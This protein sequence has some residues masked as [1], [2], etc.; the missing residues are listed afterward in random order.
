MLR[1]RRRERRTKLASLVVLVLVVA[2][3]AAIGVDRA[4][5]FVRHL[6]PQHHHHIASRVTPSTTVATTT[7]PGPPRCTSE[8]LQAYLFNWQITAGVLYEDVA[9]AD[10]SSAPC[11]LAGF[12]GLSVIAPGGGTLPSPVS[13]AA[14]L[15]ASA[16]ASTTPVA[17]SPGGRAWFELSY[18]VNCSMV[19]APGQASSTAP[20]DCYQGATLGVVVP[21]ATNTLD[22]DQ[23][24]SFTYG[25]AGFTVGPFGSQAPPSAPPTS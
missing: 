12:V 1:R 2:G 22:V 19:L 20:G 7:I 24:L 9:L 3:A 16:G 13:D 21:G 25:T 18:P 4:V 6:L 11:T 15:G 14:G 8:Q 10:A 5:V 17:L 23:P